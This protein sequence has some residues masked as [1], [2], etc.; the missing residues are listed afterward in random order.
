MVVILDLF[1]PHLGGQELIKKVVQEFPHIPVIVM[2]A[3]DELDT[4]V[5]CMKAGAFDYLVKPV[6][7]W[8]RG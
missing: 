8:Q 7:T 3:S 5:T 1:M 4:A 2:T 6:I